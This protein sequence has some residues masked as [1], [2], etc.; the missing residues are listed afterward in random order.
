MLRYAQNSICD[1][2]IHILY[3]GSDLWAALYQL[4]AEVLSSRE[5]LLRRNQ[6]NKNLSAFVTDADDHI[7]Q[8]SRLTVLVVWLDAESRAKRANGQHDRST[9]RMLY[10]AVVD[11]NDAMRSRGK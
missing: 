3:D 4:V 6:R 7:A 9:G 1:L 10:L 11:W 8:K 2:R 5:S